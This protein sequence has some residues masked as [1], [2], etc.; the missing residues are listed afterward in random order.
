MC[1]YLQN[2]EGIQRNELYAEALVH[3][4]RKNFDCTQ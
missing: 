4:E 3:D 2:L 1:V